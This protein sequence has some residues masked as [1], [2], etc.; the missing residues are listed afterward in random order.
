M[1]IGIDLGGTKIEAIL[2]TESGE[3]LTRRRIE[4]PRGDYHATLSA[5][6]Q[7]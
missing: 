3:E 1:R 7:L 6:G 4:C 2:L 5:V